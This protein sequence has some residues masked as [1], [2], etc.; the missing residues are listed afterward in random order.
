MARASR[1][2]GFDMTYRPAETVFGPPLI[3]H[4]PSLVYLGLALGVVGLVVA[5]EMSPSGSWLF[6]YVVEQDV[7]RPLGARPFA[8]IF[9]LSALAAVARTAMR[10]VRIH[11]DGLE[12]REMIGWG[13]PRVRRYKWPQIDTIVLDLEHSVALD[14]WDGSRAYLPTVSD[15]PGLATELEKI[16]AARA[17]PVRG[18]KGL[19]E[20]PDGEEYD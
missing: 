20:M 13:W 2:P 17:I 3:L 12:C 11:S 7:H 6:R 14:L 9:F 8:V 4:A 10:G 15:R 19:D 5:G 16:G 18:G 1:P